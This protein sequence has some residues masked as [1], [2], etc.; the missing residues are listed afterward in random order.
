MSL[1]LTK[2]NIPTDIQLKS[3]KKLNIQ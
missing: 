2:K 1:Q 3:I